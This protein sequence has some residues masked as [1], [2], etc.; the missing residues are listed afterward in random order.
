MT[1]T[2]AANIAKNI[3]ELRQAR[4]LTQEQLA[5]MSGVP[6]TTWAHLEAGSA[7]P[8]V[9]VLA[10]IASS[11]QVSIEE[12]MSPPRATCKLY[13]AAELMTRKRGQIQ[14]RK[15]LPDL[16][17]SIDLER[18]ELPPESQMSGIPHRAGTREYL[19][20]ET[21]EVELTVSGQTF[22]LKEG[23]VVV[24]RGDQKHSYSNRTNR[25]AIAYSTVL[26]KPP[27]E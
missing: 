5:R 26:I 8:T 14:I 22:R 2:L 3:R 18:M 10:K 11:L 9:S 15:I 1:E 19:T 21:G 23:D 24:F 17:Q 6:R 25:K 27:E 13:R 7:N 20:C 12:L 4:G 16:I